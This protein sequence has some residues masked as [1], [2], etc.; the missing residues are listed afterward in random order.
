MPMQVY[1]L[2]NKAI[3]SADA[4]TGLTVKPPAVNGIKLESFIFDVFPQVRFQID[5]SCRC[6]SQTLSPPRPPK[7]KTMA[8]LQINRADEFSPVKNAPGAPDDSPVTA[9]AMV[10]AAHQRWLIAAGATV[11]G[12]VEVSPLV[13]CGGEGL[14]GFAGRSFVGPTL[15]AA[16]AEM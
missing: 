9:R 4:V 7:A 10:L 6:H 2:A 14:A 15:I 16:A 8:V 13:S 3:P 11:E 1:H 12:D 5:I